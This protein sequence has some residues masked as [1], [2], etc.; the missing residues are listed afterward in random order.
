MKL[1][2]KL[3]LILALLMGPLPGLGSLARADDA[4]TALE[5]KVKAVVLFNFA[6]YVQWPKAVFSSP[7]QPLKICLF[8]ENPM[9][10][11]FKSNDVPREAQGHPVSIVEVAATA[12]QEELASCQILYADKARKKAFESLLESLHQKGVLTV[13]DEESDTTL[14]SFMLE[15]GKVRFRIRKETAEKHGFSMSSQLLKLAVI[16]D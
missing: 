13:F 9:A 6:K 8:S 14:I 2:R 7:E 5:F 16:E 11:V 12:T 3:V 15:D 1:L 10:G 4:A